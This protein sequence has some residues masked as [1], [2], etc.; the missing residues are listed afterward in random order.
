M[1]FRDPVQAAEHDGQD[2][3]DVL[4][5]QAEDVLVVPEVQ[6]PLG[7]L[8]GGGGGGGGKKRERERERER[9]SERDVGMERRGNTS[10][11]VGQALLRNQEYLEV[12]ISHTSGDLL[13]QGLLDLLE[14]RGLDDVQDLLDL[15]Q[16]HHL[17]PTKRCER[18]R[19]AD[20]KGYR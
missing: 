13:E 9:E 19:L 3:V 6:R 15:P 12:G 1:L 2:L 8:P 18:G 10:L 16:V 20:N 11:D 4:L 14:L 17:V 5:D 7:H